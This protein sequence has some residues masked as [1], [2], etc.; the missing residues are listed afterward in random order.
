MRI[1]NNVSAI[2]A[3]NSVNRNTNAATKSMEKLSTGLRINRAAD[4]AAGL[5]VSEKMRSQLKGLEQA[6]KNSQD[7]VSYLQTAEGALNEVS[8]M[9]VRL[10]E[11][12]VQK[13]NGTLS[14]EDQDAIALEMDELAK[15]INNIADN[16]KFNGIEVFNAGVEMRVGDDVTQVMQI[17]AASISK[18]KALTSA[19]TSDAIDAAIVELNTQRATYGALQN[20]LEH[21]MN[22]LTAT[23]EN[24][25]AAESRIRDTDMAKEMVEYTKNNILN[26]AAQSMLVQAN[27]A[28]NNVLQ[29]LR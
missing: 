9:A 29:L 10:K 18:V 19:S 28:P 20:R 27:Q 22:N 3:H 12:S 16:T 1:N 7:A 2:N 21:N 11:L 25:T 23:H 14:S 24:L 6:N 15:E 8:S 4:D 26:Q 17:S 13:A 5:A